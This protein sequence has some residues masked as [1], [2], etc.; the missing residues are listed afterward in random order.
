[1][2]FVELKICEKVGKILIDAKKLADT[3]DYAL[4]LAWLNSD[5]FAEIIK[6]NEIYCSQARSYVARC[7]INEAS[8][9]NTSEHISINDDV[10][11][12]F[13]YLITFWCF[14]QDILPYGI[15]QKYDIKRI[16]NGYDA[17]HSLSAKM[18]INIIEENFKI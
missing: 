18:A 2:H 16:L 9:E 10:L 17:L 11:F 12:W 15:S 7:F 8:I 6:G 5:I 1:M 4:V 14:E 3:D 13:G